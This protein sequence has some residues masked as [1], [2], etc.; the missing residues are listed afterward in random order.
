MKVSSGLTL[1]FDADDTLWENYI[2]FDRAI[3]EFI[4]FLDHKQHSPEEVRDALNYWETENIARMGYGLP[5]FEQSLVH[6]FE[7][8]AQVP[9]NEE[10]RARIRGF[11][12]GIAGAPVELLD[13]VAETLAAL[14]DRHELCLVTKGIPVEQLD[15]LRR[16]GL[17]S[18][19]A[20]VEVLAEKS[21]NAYRN[22]LTR[23]GWPRERCWMIG[24]S[25]KSDVL[26]PLAAGLNVVHIPHR[27]T[28]VLEHCEI[29]AP[30]PP[31]Q[32]VQLERFAD[33]LA[34]FA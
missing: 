17:K 21:E 10:Q 4:T 13:G 7:D 11:A 20:T 12:H 14:K 31:Q 2:Y 33:L 5:S 9:L 28:W 22:L 15:K 32:L 23:H 6:C 16:S 8:L 25:P 24:N 3:A 30:T 29:A 19:F 18:F 26:A 34:V 27:Q 1:L